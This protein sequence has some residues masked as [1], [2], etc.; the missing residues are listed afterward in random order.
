[1]TVK[2]KQTGKI[3]NTNSVWLQKEWSKNPKRFLT[4]FKTEEPKKEIETKEKGDK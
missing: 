1:M 3:L 2:D 4:N